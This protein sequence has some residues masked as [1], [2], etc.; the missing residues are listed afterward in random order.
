MAVPGGGAVFHE[1]GTPVDVERPASGSGEAPLEG[2]GGEYL[3]AR[4]DSVGNTCDPFIK[5]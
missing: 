3:V 2:R 4:G 1:R 5:T